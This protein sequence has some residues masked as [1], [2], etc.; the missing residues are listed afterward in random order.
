M[1]FIVFNDSSVLLS[2]LEA[3]TQIYT[4][5]AKWFKEMF[6]FQNVPLKVMYLR[7]KPKGSHIIFLS[8]E[9]TSPNHLRFCFFG[10]D[11]LPRMD[12]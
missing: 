5:T 2:E 7:G 12:M 8:Q 10:C 1:E 6:D 3:D 9:R 11:S 4:V